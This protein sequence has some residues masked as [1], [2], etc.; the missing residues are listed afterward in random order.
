M[1]HVSGPLDKAGTDLKCC[2]Q[3]GWVYPQLYLHVEVT[4]IGVHLVIQQLWPSNPGS[5]EPAKATALSSG[6][7]AT[8]PEVTG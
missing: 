2:T 7:Q 6:K 4:I 3:H 8:K 1:A 5:A